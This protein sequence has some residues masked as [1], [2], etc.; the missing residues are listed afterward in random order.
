MCHLPDLQAPR[1]MVDVRDDEQHGGKGEQ[2]RDGHRD[3]RRGLVGLAVEASQ[4]QDAVAER[5]D[6]QADDDLAQ[7][8]ADERAQDSRGELTAGQL[9]AHHGQGEHDAGCGDGGTGDG[10]QQPR[11]RV[12]RHRQRQRRL[13]LGVVKRAGDL[14]E[15]DAADDDAGREQEQA[16]AEAVRHGSSTHP[17]RQMR[18]HPA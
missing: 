15:C 13:D 17:H 9:Q 18:A 5:R 1:E 16:F 3:S 14:G 10:A 11:R 6:E 8:V 2:H 7:P 4:R 12:R